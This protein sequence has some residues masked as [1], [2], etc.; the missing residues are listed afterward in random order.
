MK[1]DFCGVAR[2]LMS[3]VISTICLLVLLATYAGARDKYIVYIG[4]YTDHGS[5]GI[6]VCE[7]DPR[8]G[9]F[10]PPE[11]A[12]ESSSPSFLTVNPTRQFL[13]AVNETD[14]FHDQPAGAVSSFSLDSATGNLNLLNQVSSHGRGPAFVTLDQTDRYALVANYGGGSVAVFPI[15][16]DGKIGD[17]T[18]F[19][20]HR[21]SSVNPE[22]QE[23]AHAHAIA[24]S[25]DNRFALVA[26]LGLDQV[27]IY[28]FDAAHG[29]LGGGRIFYSHP[30]DG[31]RHLV[32]SADGK[33]VYV[34]NELT[35]TVTV[36]AYYPLEGTIS[37]VQNISTLPS[38]F[39]GK[40]T[41]AEVALHPSGKFLYASNRGDDNS[42][43]EFAVDPKNGKLTF[44]ETVLTQGKTP[45]SF[46]IDTS[47]KWM[48]VANQDSN[49]VIEFRINQKTGRIVAT[50]Q[51][52]L[53][54]SP[55]M[56]DFVSPAGGG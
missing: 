6:Y 14:Q 36:N 52:M 7:F 44:V 2:V 38:G 22:R 24:M 56:V 40:N 9:R 37:S 49:T 45:R 13:Y 5:R 35:S 8:K 41:A 31:P 10:T 47:G 3:V 23:A 48:L 34:I 43:A 50:G 46:A 20:L 19:L 29:T 27:L 55:A 33:F 28:P 18:A 51:S 39:K 21:G 26:D 32:F 16:P 42:I 54:N 30:G 15:L 11:L 25:P 17:A 53:L 12:A 4:T 1:I